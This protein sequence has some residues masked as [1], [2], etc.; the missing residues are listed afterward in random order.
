LLVQERQNRIMEILEEKGSV[1]VAELTSLF[2][3]SIETIRRD[4]EA[5]EKEG[6]LKRVYGG[7]ILVG[8]Y[9]KKFDFM[10]RTG[11]FTKEKSEIA[12]IASRYVEEGQT[13]TVNGGTT[14]L[15]LI[16][17]LKAKF[18]KLTVLTNSLMIANEL[19]TKEGFTTIVTGGIL[20][21][22][23]FSFVGKIAEEIIL[24]FRVDKAFISTG[25]VSLNKGITDYI[26]EE[27]DIQKRMIEIS[28]EVVILADNSK[29]DNVS[30]MKVADL[31]DIDLIVSDSGLASDLVK[32]Y[33]EKGVEIINR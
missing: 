13:I 20:N 12:E 31:A 26:I 2:D 10:N 15:E 14:S 25:G 5:L 17:V 1:K 16:K 7:A 9:Q 4:L 27:I 28:K 6:L 22:K 18:N 19:V 24:N 23:E 29:I 30:L 21:N 8:D 32:K 11:E 3:L 33:A